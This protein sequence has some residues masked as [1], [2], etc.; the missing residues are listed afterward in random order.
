[1]K[2]KMLT[3]DIQSIYEEKYRDIKYRNATEQDIKKVADL[4]RNTILLIYPRY[5]PV[6][7]VNFFLEHHKE[8]NIRRDIIN[9]HVW[10]I[11]VDGKV[12]GT[13][14]YKDN[15]ITRVYVSANY[16]NNG[17]GNFIMQDLEDRIFS[18]YNKV[19]LDSSLPASLLYEKRGYRTIKHCQRS[20]ENDAV[21]VYEIM[22]K[23]VELHKTT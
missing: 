3:M 17:F 23:E 8:D 19:T 14:S 16:Q 5:Y 1:M 6:G 20:V 9:E 18:H 4:V 11:T 22:E 13:G 15:H 12:V 2:P 21:L 7:V 10:I